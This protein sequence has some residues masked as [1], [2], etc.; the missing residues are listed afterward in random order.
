MNLSKQYRKVIHPKNDFFLE[1][2]YNAAEVRV[3]LALS[4]FKQPETDIHEWNRIKFGYD[5]RSEAKNNIIRVIS[6][7]LCLYFF[8]FYIAANLVGLGRI[9]ES[10]FNSFEFVLMF[11]FSLYK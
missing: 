8:V 6:G 2:D 11:G 5:D 7:I 9:F 10:A 3:F 4:G 1:L